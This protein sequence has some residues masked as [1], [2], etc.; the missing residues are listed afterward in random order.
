[1]KK[2]LLMLVAVAIALDMYQIY[3]VC[4][5]LLLLINDMNNKF[6]YGSILVLL[7]AI[8]F[9]MSFAFKADALFLPNPLLSIT[10]YIVILSMMF[11][12]A[13][14]TSVEERRFFFTVFCLS[15]II[16]GL[17][18]I[19]YSY[20]LSL[21]TSSY[22][23]YGRLFNPIHNV[24]TISPKIALS[25]LAPLISYCLLSQ[26]NRVALILILTLSIYAFVFVQSRISIVISVIIF[27]TLL[28]YE[29]SKLKPSIK[30]LL[31]FSCLIIISGFMLDYNY[32]SF[33]FS[34]NRL[35]SSGLESKR[36]LHWKDGLNKIIDHPFG[37]FKV[38]PN[39]EHVNYFH[40]I[41]IDSARIY[42]WFAIFLIVSI[43]T[44]QVYIIYKY[45]RKNITRLVFV[46]VFL[47]LIMMQDVVIEGNFLLLALSL[48][49]SFLSCH[50]TFGEKNVSISY[51]LCSK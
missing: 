20:F 3:L 19:Y 25:I 31:A 1:M 12:F 35:V 44:T 40:N 50:N 39:I 2:T 24:D 33:D 51:S 27:L 5:A 13:F 49:I 26:P 48:F 8:V 10:K 18:I 16:N 7:L 14:F 47:T 30:I 42:G 23:G 34:D 37:G 21:T 17:I 29:Y 45:N 38:D 46:F 41:I 32:T 9:V 6:N 4:F 22:F 15:M 11:Y 36:F 28:Y 43:F